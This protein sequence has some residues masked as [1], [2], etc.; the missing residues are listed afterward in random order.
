M[1]PGSVKAIIFAAFVFAV[2]F[3]PTDISAQ[4][5]DQNFPTPVLDNEITGTIDAR[6]IGDSRSTTYYYTFDGGQGDL[7]IN[8][9]TNNLTADID[10]FTV[11]GLRPMTKV[12]VYADLDASETGRVIYL[13]KRE[14]LLLRIQGRTPNDDPATFHLKFAGSFIAAAPAVDDRPELPEI[15][16]NTNVNSVGT[17][18]PQA[19]T[20][21]PTELAKTEPET[22]VEPA[23]TERKEAPAEIPAQVPVARQ[24]E[25]A[26]NIDPEESPA[27]EPEPAK[28]VEDAV[29]EIVAETEV[30]PVEEPETRVVPKV[31]VTD[32]LV[33]KEETKLADEAEAVKETAEE[34]A[35]EKK[36][37]TEAEMLASIKLVVIFKDG[38]RIERPMSDVL[39]FTVDRGILTIIS[40][41]GSI[42]RYSL[43]DI[44]RTVIE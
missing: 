38:G 23:E 22:P 2:L 12:V 21:E 39:R 41:N 43:I 33:A 10:V 40:K 17:I 19:R 36:E 5:S 18:I 35:P 30:E 6:D 13:R 37:K 27:N 42:G 9:V 8:L 20:E 44:E 1:K 32:P 3:S 26:E 31:I 14:K 7:F 34:K 29:P 15:A 28:K 25:V 11:A 24:P 4:S 16:R